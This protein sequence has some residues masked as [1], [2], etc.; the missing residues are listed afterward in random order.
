MADI[1]TLVVRM[2]ADSAK[3]RSDLERVQRDLRSTGSV[4]DKLGGQFK[5]LGGVVAGISL[6]ALATQA[7]QL[8]GALNDTSIRTGIATD[9]LQRLQFAAGLSGSSLEAVSGAVA[10]MQKALVESGEGSEQARQALSQIGLSAGEVFSLAPDKQFEAIAVAISGIADPAQRAN[11]AMDLFGRSGAE[12]LPLLE[13]LGT[14]AEGVAAQ[15]SAIGGPVSAEAIAKVDT[16]GDQIDVLTAGA[17][18]LSLELM[19]LAATAL[20][21]L[22][23][24]TNEWVGSLR[25]LTGG[26]GELEQLQQKL[27]ILQESRD[28]IPIFFNFG[29]VE[30]QGLVLGKR[31]LDSA[32]ADV[33]RRIRGL[34]QAT[35]QANLAPL[36]VP[37]DV[38]SPDVPDFGA[39]AAAGARGKGKAATP[40]MTAAERRAASDKSYLM[41]LNL[42]AL[43]AYQLQEQALDQHLANMVAM[44]S[45]AALERVRIATD[46]EMFRSDVAQAFGLQQLDFEAIKNQSIIGLAGELFTALGSES[47]KLFKVQKAFAIANAVVNVAEGITQALRL[48]FPANLA[49]AAK[50]A[51]AGAIQIAKIKATNPGGGAAAPSLSGGSGAGAGNAA[52]PDNA[53]AFAQQEPQRIAQVVVQGNLF[54]A[55][56]TADW[57]IEQLS[58]AVNNRDV[59]FINGASRQ[60][61]AIAGAA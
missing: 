12:L 6:T 18:N 53:P 14:N 21:P 2:A 26:G 52:L 4:A 3:M 60:A 17:K 1:G 5:M 51:A 32:I 49:A 41:T 45:A 55:R 47:S 57:L 36:S 50:V 46:L 7:I 38:L 15:L 33:T 28:S 16:L 48:P 10:R 22:I 34:Q 61:G 25:V 56:E 37:V 9:A 29:Y 31:G 30:G 13:N 23:E 58:D 42:Q 59:V 43:E 54:S 8:A 39:S 27:R 35:S 44:D 40:E 19:A 20:V 24:K 11:A